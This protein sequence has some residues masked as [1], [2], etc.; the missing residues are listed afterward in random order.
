MLE[1][2]T[3]DGAVPVLTGLPKRAL[4]TG[5]YLVDVG[6]SN[7]S[8]AADSYRLIDVGTTIRVPGAAGRRRVVR[9]VEDQEA[10]GG[11]HVQPVA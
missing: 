7:E 5:N 8:C 6:R 9:L 3:Y 1:Q 10:P 2:Q 4:D 11:K